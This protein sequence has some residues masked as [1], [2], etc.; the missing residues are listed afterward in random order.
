MGQYYFPIIKNDKTGEVKTFYSHDYNNGLKLT[1]HSYI[2]NNFVDAVLTQLTYG[3]DRLYWVGDYAEYD[4]LRKNPD[5]N[6]SAEEFDAITDAANNLLNKQVD[7]KP[8][9]LRYVFNL[10]KREYIDLDRLKEEGPR[11]AWDFVIN[12][13]PLL[14]SVGNGK[15]GGDYYDC[16][17]CADY[18][19]YWAGDRLF[20]LNETTGFEDFRDATKDYIFIEDKNYISEED[21]EDAL[22]LDV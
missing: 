14:C 12:P 6:I 13:V 3:D 22:I 2:G 10:T 16:Y 18:C 1:E 9:H 21:E 8:I 17:P 7:I 19:G 15:G 4:D 20:S 5:C 11:D